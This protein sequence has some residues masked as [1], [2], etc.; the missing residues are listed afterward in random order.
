MALPD[1][2]VWMGKTPLANRDVRHLYF[3]FPSVADAE[4][5]RRTR[6]AILERGNSR[7][8]AQLAK[9]L[10]KAREGMRADTA[11]CPVLCRQF[12]IW[13][14]GAALAIHEAIA[15]VGE[16]YSVF[17]R[18]DA[19]DVGMLHTIN[20][21]RLHAGMRNRAATILGVHS[22]VVGMATVKYDK[23]RNKWQPHYPMMIYGGSNRF[24]NFYWTR[25]TGSPP[26][27]R[28]LHEAAQWFG[29]MSLAAFGEMMKTDGRSRQGRLNDKLSREYFHYLANRTPTSFVFCFN[30]DIGNQRVTIPPIEVNTYEDEDQ[31]DG[32]SWMFLDLG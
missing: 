12:Q 5:E 28:A 2:S 10:R 27:V 20:L 21:R 30:C 11:C 3:G 32:P 29:D 16:P 6:I 26:M 8:S 18:D 1:Q 24:R 25:R 15:L 7:A 22:A 14:V 31:D 23:T 19:V 17:D 4:Q 13:F 9:V